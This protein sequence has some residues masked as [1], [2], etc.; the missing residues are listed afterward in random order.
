MIEITLEEFSKLCNIS[1]FRHLFPVLHMF[2]I[3][4]DVNY[5]DSTI[6]ITDTSGYWHYS[7]TRRSDTQNQEQHIII[8]DLDLP[9]APVDMTVLRIYSDITIEQLVSFVVKYQKLQV[10]A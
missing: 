3:D 8:T 10:F 9:G 2:N 5:C 7:K 6:T 4:F 1:K